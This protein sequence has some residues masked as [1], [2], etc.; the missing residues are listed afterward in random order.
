MGMP[1]TVITKRELS[2]QIVADYAAQHRFDSLITTRTTYQ[3]YHLSPQLRLR[4]VVLAAVLVYKQD[5]RDSYTLDK[6][7]SVNGRKPCMWFYILAKLAP[8]Q[9]E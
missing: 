9:Y 5:Y 2:F 1:H 6:S 8:S 7:A 3:Y 4:L